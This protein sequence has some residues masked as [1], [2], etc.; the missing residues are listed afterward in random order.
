MPFQIC[1]CSRAAAIGPGISGRAVTA[2]VICLVLA[3]P[4]PFAYGRVRRKYAHR[5]GRGLA[6]AAFV[7]SIVYVAQLLAGLLLGNLLLPHVIGPA[8]APVGPF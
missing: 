2:G 1:T 4:G 5:P 3:I 6:T 8:L 7:V